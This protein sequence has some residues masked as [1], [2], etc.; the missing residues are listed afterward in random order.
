[1]EEVQNGTF[2]TLLCDVFSSATITF[3][4]LEHPSVVKILLLVFLGNI[5]SVLLKV[6][7]HF[8]NI[9]QRSASSLDSYEWQGVWNSTG[10]CLGWWAPLEFWNFTPEQVQNPEKQCWGLAHAY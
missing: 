9:I 1:M 3:Q 8:K 6:S 7:K 10:R 2:A 5:V 4:Y